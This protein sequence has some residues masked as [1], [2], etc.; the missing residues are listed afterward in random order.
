MSAVGTMGK[1]GDHGADTTLEI[2]SRGWLLASGAFTRMGGAAGNG[3]HEP[4][5]MSDAVISSFACMPAVRRAAALCMSVSHGSKR[6]PTDDTS[7]NEELKMSTVL[8][9]VEGFRTGVGT[10]TG[11]H[12]VFSTAIW[13]GCGIVGAICWLSTEVS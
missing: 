1:S 12:S 13:E 4:G 9:T 5:K 10:S 11:L 8:T 2:P 6:I 7:F 3:D